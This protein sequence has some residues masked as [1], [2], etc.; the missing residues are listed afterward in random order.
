MRCKMSAPWRE[1]SRRDKS[2]RPRQAIT[3]IE[4]LVVIFIIGLLVALLLPAVQAARVAAMRV[5]CANNL[6]QIG[7]AIHSYADTF[8]GRFPRSTHGTTDFESTWIYTLAPFME[9]VDKI[10]ICPA[11]PKWKERLDNQGTS[12]VLN[13]YICV[14]GPDQA[15][16]LSDLRATSRTIVVFTGS[17][18][19]GFAITEDHTHSRNWFIE[20]TS[21]T[22]KR[23][24]ADIQPNRFNG[25]G[26]NTPPE[27]RATGYA[28]YLFADG[29][30]QVIPG[31]QIRAWSDERTNFALPDNC[32]EMP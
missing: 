23:I 3:L 13:E 22:W 20:P 1:V 30:V 2:R 15:L 11:D 25:G 6:H 19:K 27:R 28:N 18:D 7:L 10:R 12:Y 24:V 16:R 8:D 9:N 5:K 14:P 31:Q 26:P 17:D 32:P 4:L 29:H 21:Q